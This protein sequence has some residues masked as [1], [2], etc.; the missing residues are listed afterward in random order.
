MTREQKRTAIG[1]RALYPE[2]NL[3]HPQHPAHSYVKEDGR[4]PR[5]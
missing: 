3:S 2:E 1:A 4:R 5:S